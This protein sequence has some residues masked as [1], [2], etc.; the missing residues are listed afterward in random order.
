MLSKYRLKA[1]VSEQVRERMDKSMQLSKVD[2]HT[3]R[4]SIIKYLVSNSTD[5]FRV[6]TFC[7]PDAVH[8]FAQYSKLMTHLAAVII[9]CSYDPNPQI[10]TKFLKLK[11]ESIYIS[12][13]SISVFIPSNNY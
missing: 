4:A 3:D 8:L 2:Y 1:G 11:T 7:S 10:Y 9:T 13:Q 12:S 6:H 5:L